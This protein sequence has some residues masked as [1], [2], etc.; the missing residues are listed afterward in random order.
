[1]LKFLFII[2]VVFFIFYIAAKLAKKYLT[3]KFINMFGSGFNVNTQDEKKEVI[4]KQDNVVVMKG[5]AQNKEDKKTDNG[6]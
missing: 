4:Y 5:E 3:N 6:R 2:L 1:M